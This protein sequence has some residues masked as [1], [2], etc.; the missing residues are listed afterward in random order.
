MITA[1]LKHFLYLF[2]GLKAIQA[3]ICLIQPEFVATLSGL[4]TSTLLKGRNPHCEY[5]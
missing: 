4:Q 2:Q 5:P 3:K 1:H